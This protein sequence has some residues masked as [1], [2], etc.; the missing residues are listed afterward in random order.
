LT[1]LIRSSSPFT[2]KPDLTLPVHWVEPKVTC[3]VRF[4]EWTADGRM[5]HATLVGLR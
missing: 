2:N 3:R 5:R 4:L 1:K